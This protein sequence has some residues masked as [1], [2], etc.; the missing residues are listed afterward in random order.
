MCIINL[1]YGTDTYL[2]SNVQTKE[3]GRK[4]R[5]RSISRMGPIPIKQVFFALYQIIIS[6]GTCGIVSNNLDHL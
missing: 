3:I 6:K 1:C 4:I 2:R 5:M